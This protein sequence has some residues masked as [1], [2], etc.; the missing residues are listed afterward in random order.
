MSMELARKDFSTTPEYLI[1]G[2]DI[3]ITTN[4]RTAAADLEKG[5]PVILD[6]DGKAAKVTAGESGVTVTS[7]YG[8]T[9]DSAKTGEDAVIY[10]TGEFFA[11][12]LVLEEGVTAEDIEVAFRNIGI[13][14]K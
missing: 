1:A 10:L 4:I 7:L 3:R 14:L 11:D 12:A 9:A 5:A 2:T 13:F 8:I 6:D